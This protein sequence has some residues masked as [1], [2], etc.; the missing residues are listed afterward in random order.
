MHGDEAPN[1]LTF[2]KSSD[3]RKRQR[4][5]PQ[6]CRRSLC[7][8]RTSEPSPPVTSDP[9]GHWRSWHPPPFAS[10]ALPS[11]AGLADYADAVEM[12]TGMN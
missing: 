7:K 4:K 9:S 11:L 1:Y 8:T 10:A 2:G 5:A 3:Y 6:E 12:T